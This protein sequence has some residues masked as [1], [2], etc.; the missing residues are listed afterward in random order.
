LQEGGEEVIVKCG[1]KEYDLNSKDVI[2]Y[3]GACYQIIT[4]EVRNGWFTYPP[5]IPTAKAIKMIKD[6][7]L[8]LAKSNK[9]LEYYKIADPA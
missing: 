2:M 5:R 6:G 3:N 9:G 8:K 4:R 7:R 1:R